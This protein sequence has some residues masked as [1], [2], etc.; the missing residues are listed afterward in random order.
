[1]TTLQA[2]RELALSLPRTTEH[3]IHD[4]VKFRVG[5]IV[6]VAFSR[7][8]ATMGFGFP[9]VERDA[10]VAAEPDKFFL[11]RQS[12]MRFNWVCTWLE[13]IA[14]EEMYE[15]VVDAWRMTVPKRVFAQRFPAAVDP[16][17]GGSQR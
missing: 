5:P 4:R 12:D 10:L 13:R 14:D 1:M 15:L 16:D 8:E 17:G 3:L 9:K 2:V 7:D 11:P 6:Y